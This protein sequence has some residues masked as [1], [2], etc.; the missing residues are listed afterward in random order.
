MNKALQIT[1]V[2]L[3]MLLVP[4]VGWGQA[5]DLLTY[6]NTE[7]T[8]SFTS[9]PNSPSMP[10]ASQPQNG[11]V[12]WV[13]TSSFN[14]QLTYTPNEGFIGTD[15]FRI[16]R[17]EIN[18][19]PS[20]TYLD[21]TVTVAPALI[22]A[23]HDYAVTYTGQ[24]VVVDVLANDISSNGVK[25]LQAVPAINHG[26]ATFNQV[27]G[28]IEFTPAP[29]FRGTAHFNYALCNGVGDC[30]DGTVSITVMQEIPSTEDEVVKVFT[31]KN[32]TQFIL[33]PEDYTLVQAPDNG[34]F[35]PG[36]DVPEYT[37]STDYI[38]TDE[39]RFTDGNHEVIFDIEVLDLATNVFA[40]DDRAFT[41]IN[42]PVEIDVQEN[43]QPLTG[44]TINV[45]VDPEHGQIIEAND[46]TFTYQP[47]PGFIGVDQFSY[48]ANVCGSGTAPEIATVTIFVSNF[49]PDRTT[50]DMA[51]PKNTPII[52]GYNVPVS[53]FNFEV[54]APG[55]LGE[56]IFL[57]G[58]VDTVINGLPIQGN[59]ILIY[60]PN[61]DVTTGLDEL[62]ITY[63]LEDPATGD[64]LVS[65]QVKIWMT[66]LD[67]GDNGEPVCV[68]DCV[69]AGDTNADGIVN[70][71][72]LLPIGRNMGDIGQER[73]G[74][75]MDVW[76][77]QY[78]DDWGSLFLGSET[79]DIKHIDADGNSIVTAL[80]TLA[81]NQHYNKTHNMVPAVM[82][83][84]PYEFILEGPLFVNPGDLVEF[85]I[86]LGTPNDP[87]ED[88]YGFV[89]PF[90]YNSDVVDESSIRI[91]WD[92]DNYLAYDSPVLYMDHNNMEGLF[93]AGYTRTSGLVANG[94]GKI[95]TLEVIV[96]DIAGI[97][98]DAD[99][100]RLQFGGDAAGTSLNALG[101]YSGIRVRPFE[102][103]VRL[104][105]EDTEAEAALTEELVKTFP[106]PANNQIT[107]HLNGGQEI[108]ELTLTTLTGQTVQYQSGL[109]T[110]RTMLDVSQLPAGMYILGVANE[111][112]RVN[113]KIQ[114]LH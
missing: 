9:M 80:D 91:T 55:E 111:N 13:S 37:P 67:I 31:K 2:V 39:I 86:S 3:A 90:A 69:W 48:S 52:I 94:H 8:Y 93:E 59:N 82:P 41:T 40:F 81:I 75:T 78:A 95:G 61:E 74:A 25:L 30:D 35:D 79:L 72:D 114:I 63:C 10:G 11:T 7:V 113:R 66:I 83:Y 26:S 92:D 58:V 65:K 88:I 51:T 102:L 1:L 23:Y 73:I 84:A 21:I 56:T 49:A 99:E 53:T 14:Y 104:A 33:I 85:T 112:G 38:G 24:P 18:P 77:G 46:G 50:F 6:Q 34:V 17:W 19:A 32:E 87:A 27:T 108:D 47:D 60:I 76:Y 62:E 5:V 43:D 15:N 110:N 22:D 44:C 89:F 4:L 45:V 98:S 20:F 16:V 57:E 106:N 28:L 100:I 68:G 103:R 101:Q 71:T 36:A 54:T 97:R 12:E 29:G 64:C 107:V 109:K 105:D 70:M 96:D 42:S